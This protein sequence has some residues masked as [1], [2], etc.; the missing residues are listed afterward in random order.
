[1]NATRKFAALAAALAALASGPALA[2]QTTNGSQPRAL[3]KPTGATP[4]SGQRYA[5]APTTP[6]PTAGDEAKLACQ[7]LLRDA[8]AAI[9]AGDTARAQQLVARASQLEVPASAFGKGEDTPATLALAL[10]Q[11]TRYYDPAVTNAGAE[12]SQGYDNFAHQALHVPG[13]DDVGVQ[14][15]AALVAPDTPPARLAQLP[16]PSERVQAEPTAGPRLLAEGE[17]KLREKDYDGAFERFQAASEVRGSL[18]SGAQR[19]LDDHLRMLG[20]TPSSEPAPLAGHAVD[21]SMIDEADKDQQVLARKLASTVGQAQVES[22]EIRESDPRRS[23]EILEAARKEVEDSGVSQEYRD[24]LVRRVAR[25]I[26]DTQDYIESN[27]AQI[28]L[29]ETNAA[30][31]GDI[32][33][34]NASEQRKRQKMQELIAEYNGLRDEYKLEEAEVVARRLKELAPD[35]P[36]AMQ[37]WE[38]AKFFRRSVINSDIREQKDQEFWNAL[39]KVDEASIPLVGGGKDIVYGKN[40]GDIKE[41]SSIS[42]ER[43]RMSPR[44]VEIKNRLKTPVQLRYTDRPLAEVMDALA[45]MTGVDIYLDPRGLNQEGVSSDTPV[46]ININSEI[47]LESALNLILDPLHLGYTIKDEV[48]KITSESLRDGEVFKE[49]YYVADL[50]IPIPNFVPSNNIGLQGLINDA[51]AVTN[52]G[53]GGLGGRGPISL[54]NGPGGPGNPDVLAQNF[55]PSGQ[56]GSS[57]QQMTSGPG[58][59]GGAASADFDSLIE[60]ITSTVASDTWA[61]NGGGEA[62]IRPFATN[63]SLVVSQTQSVHEEIADLLEQL[64]R[65]QDLQVTIEVRF[66]RLSDDFFERIGIDFDMNIND[67]ILGTNELT[68]TSTPIATSSFGESVN[69]GIRRTQSG[70]TVGVQAPLVGDLATVTADLDLPFRQGS[71]PI[72][73]PQFG[74]FN[75][76]SAATFGFAILSDIEAYFLINAAQGDTR[77]NVL[78]APKVTL[79]NGQQAFV[80]DTSQSPFV[81]SVVPVVGEFAAAQQ[82]V[83]VVLNEGTLMSIQAVVSEDRRYVRLTVVPFFSEI[84]DV[85]VFTFDGS[86]TTNASASSSATDANDDG[87]NEQANASQN[88]QI[89]TAGTTVQLPTFQFVSVTTTVSVPDGGT[90]L[91]GGIKRLSEGRREFGVPLLSKVPYINR[92]F[93]NVGIG[94][95]TD[96]LMMMVTPRIIIQEEEEQRLGLAGN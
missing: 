58:G 57:P 67:R 24:Q 30:I 2:Q 60:L 83:I 95:E 78:N 90:V 74:G 91:L 16:L 73:Q 71:F 5:L 29:D 37:V 53:A 21:A 65:L 96:S 7:R 61:E 47:S 3:P 43:G 88:Q 50:V 92:L 86:T 18:D 84:G 76:T 41:R 80:S 70:A 63:L 48:L 9:T 1:M 69:N 44:E 49:V 8:R 12:W 72:A 35:D 59:L 13:Q 34:K 25:S 22:R 46:T 51:L 45:K 89:T 26:S 81:I 94:R 85:D 68:Q 40:W 42:R 93:R 52:A 55:A 79:F 56:I 14:P 28:E 4:A 75:P 32:D 6:A 20:G 11:P 39:A 54:A 82:P 87:T 10:R 38:N 62:E 66:I 36:V 64:R 77:T 33:R 15:A 17:Q 31:I 27:K 23:L 19:R